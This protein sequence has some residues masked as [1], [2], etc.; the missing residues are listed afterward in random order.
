MSRTDSEARKDW[1]G[2]AGILTDALPF[3]RRY[4]GSTVVVKFGGHAMGDKSL[5]KTFASDMVLLKQVGTNPLVVH[6]GGPQIGEML[7]RMAI[8]SEFIDGLRVTDE[9]TVDIVEM[10][11][12][13]SIN[14]SIVAA[15]NEAGGR[16]VGISG[17]D[18]NLITAKRLLR[19]RTDPESNIEKV[20]DLGFVGEPTNIDSTLIDTLI[21]GGL[22]PVIAPVGQGNDGETYNINADTVAGAIAGAADAKRMLMLT[23]VEG[24]LDQ[25]GQLIP[26]LT[27]EKANKLKENGVISGGMIPKI[28][29]CIEAVR[30]GAEAAVILDGRVPH[31]VLLELFTSQG[32]G[33]IIRSD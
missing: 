2:K 23:D 26:D 6:G 28:E 1:L 4:A 27:I 10:V 30:Q 14:K 9:A 24:V 31:A 8:K 25:S 5:F 3:M 21:L 16:A 7:E 29:T 15:I 20:V 11:L 33:T 18:A 22:I 17:K 19:T 12:A 32:H 13:G